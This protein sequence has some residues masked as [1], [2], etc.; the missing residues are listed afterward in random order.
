MLYILPVLFLHGVCLFT[1]FT[2]N[3]LCLTIVLRAR[4]NEIDK[5]DTSCPKYLAIYQ[6]RGKEIRIIIKCDES[7]VVRSIA[8]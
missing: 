2:E 4:E 1:I 6:G 3:F 5:E 7:Y 8:Y